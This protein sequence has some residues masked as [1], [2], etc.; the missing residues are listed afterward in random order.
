MMFGGRVMNKILSG[1]P[2]GMAMILSASLANAQIIIVQPTIQEMLDGGSIT[3]NDKV[4]SDWILVDES[5]S[6]SPI[7]WNHVTLDRLYNPSNPGLAF[8]SNGEFT[9]QNLTFQLQFTVSTTSGDPLIKDLS[10][11][12]KDFSVS[13][14]GTVMAINMHMLD[15]DAV[16]PVIVSNLDPYLFDSESF[17]PVASTRLLMDAS[18]GGTVGSLDRFDLRV[19]QV[20]QVP[21]PATLTLL[22]VGLAGIGYMRRKSG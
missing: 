19:S 5:H 3:V 17:A 15:T 16:N 12:M 4:F 22:G 10:M 21:E 1:L 7:N 20:S 9:L 8:Y 18:V 2:M 11:E 6:V 14:G 13:I